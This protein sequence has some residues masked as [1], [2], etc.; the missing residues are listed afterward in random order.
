M[1][2]SPP[3]AVIGRVPQLT[4]EPLALTKSSAGK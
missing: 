1:R 4:V 3:V 2:Y